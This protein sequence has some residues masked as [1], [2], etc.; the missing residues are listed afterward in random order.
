M[1]QSNSRSTPA[2]P[3]D[4]P[5][6]QSS[7]LSSIR[8]HSDQPRNSSP[9]SAHTHPRSTFNRTIRHLLPH[10]RPTQ[11]SSHPSP[12]IRKRWRSSR[13]FSKQPSPPLP[14]LPDSTSDDQSHPPP[15]IPQLDPHPSTSDRDS[16]HCDPQLANPPLR[17]LPPPRP[18]THR[19]PSP[20]LPQASNT[21]D[22]PSLE[23]SSPV[24]T[25]PQPLDSN[26]PHLELPQHPP[27][28]HPQ[29]PQLPHPPCQTDEEVND[30]HSDRKTD[31][32]FTQGSSQD[33][34]RSTPPPHP[35]SR[36][37]SSPFEAHPELA[38]DSQPHPPRHFQS[39]GPLVVVQ[40]V[41]N[42]SDNP[43]SPKR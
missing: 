22:P 31:A 43:A 35:E 42:T 34:Q 10:P 1:G 37:D 4:P 36:P 38:L 21:S 40:G 23:D 41:V 14:N 39:P 26:P 18:S 17:Q 5:R 2:P 30:L 6:S 25:Q 8:D 3:S 11:D 13:R 33:G 32:I 20:V 19:I 27:S 9:S 29:A 28:H 15:S 24:K 7:I 12:S 16:Q